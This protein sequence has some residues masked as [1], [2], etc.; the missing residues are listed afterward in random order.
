[1]RP[2]AWLPLRKF[3]AACVLSA[4]L[5][6]C[7]VLGQSVS[8]TILGTVR[9]ESGAVVP[10]ASVSVVHRGTGFSRTFTTDARGEYVAPL[11]PTGTYTVSAARPEFQAAS[12]P[13]VHVGVDQK[14]RIDLTLR[15]AAL[16]DVVDV[17]A[18]PTLLQTSSSDL[19]TTIGGEEVQALPLNGRNFVSLTR[20][21]PG[22]LR[23]VPGANIDGAGGVA[24][25][26]SASFS[27]NGQRPRDNNYLL[28]GVDNNETWLQSVVIYPSVD[29]L[30]EFKLQT[31]TYAAEFGKSLG[32]VVSLQTR[33]GTNDYHGRVFGFLRDDALDANNFFNNRSGTPKAPFRQYQYGGT[34]GG[35]VRKDA[36]FFFASYQGLRSDQGVNRLSTVPSKAMREGDFSELN[37]KIYDP[38]TGQPFP[39][40]VI[41]R[42]RWNAASASVLDLLI[43]VSNTPGQ[44]SEPSGQ[45]INNYILNPIQERNDDQFDLRIDHV[46]G[47]QNRIFARYSWERSHRFLPPSFPGGDGFANVDGTILAQSLVV[48]DTHTF[49]P[50]WLNE[51]RLGY[52]SFDL[53]TTPRGAEDLEEVL[54]IPGMNVTDFAQG[55]S[56]IAFAQGGV[57]A[58]SA[59]GLGSGQPMLANLRTFQVVDDLTH[60]RGRHTLKAGASL[61]LRR[62]EILNSDNMFG[63]FVFHQNQTSSCAGRPAPCSL[64]ATTG[65]DFASF[66]LGYANQE[67]RAFIGEVPYVETRPEWGLYLQDDLRANERL[68]LNFGLRW[69]VFVPWVEEDDRQSNFDPSTG[70]FVVA[71]DDAVIDGVR[72]GRHLQTWSRADLGPRFGFAYDLRGNGLTIVRGGMGVFWNWGPGGTSS[73]K[74][75]NPPFLRS[76]ARAS[77]FGTNLV[78]SDGP[79]PLP[80]VDPTAP[81]AGTTR[82]AFLRDV[83]DSYAVNWNLNVQQQLGRHYMVEVTYVGSSG[84]NL[85]LKTDLNR[86]PPTLGVT[87]ADVNRP[88]IRTAPLLR[89]VGTVDTSGTL[90]YDA[91][92]VKL[93]RR[94]T[95]GFSFLGAYTLGKALDLASDNDGA[96]TLTDVRH[97]DYNHGP[98]DY[99]VRH[100]VSATGHWEIPLGRGRGWGGWQASGILYWRTGLP[101]TITQ[102][103]GVQSNGSFNRP[104]RVGNGN[105]AEPT[106]DRWFDPTA[107]RPTS[108]PTATFGNAGRNILRGPG[109]WNIDVSLVKLTRFGKVTSELRVEAFNVLNHPQFAAPFGP[110]ASFGNTSFG[111]ITA[112]LGNPACATCGTTERQIQIGLKLFF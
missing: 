18:E 50:S 70:R 82:S 31:S 59:A 104:N 85:V 86:A 41:P 80:P 108:E 77:T 17:Q 1:M 62:R 101:V 2:V 35:P 107:F 96:V 28:D 110:S 54:G 34:L 9:D 38:R 95:N 33:A 99:D 112:M 98:A 105:A 83:R 8:G 7:A 69:D 6:P 27:A 91:L 87:N 102:T 58:G 97:P 19:S 14:A 53:E 26:A 15:I 74:A 52:S 92:L 60:V 23:G 73:S 24:W 63:S 106:I 111:T 44:R 76:A 30:D 75:Q 49:G 5:V 72:V 103:Q 36:T 81:P 100:T 16:T 89:T 90:E 66:L 11:L 32:G 67:G 84:C 51:L 22:I 65:F 109:Q 3:L 40:N 78:L 20:T 29:A 39:G 79:P 94:F 25:R 47:S 48:N 57:R 55:M 12:V 68:T 10:E 61:T 4:V 13:G 64:D 45:I 93:Q 88:Y 71:S 56:Q 46:L 43:P 42:D 21:V 37:R